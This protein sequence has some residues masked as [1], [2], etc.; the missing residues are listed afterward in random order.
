MFIVSFK[1][2]PKKVLIAGLALALAVSAGV[3]T[4]RYRGDKVVETSKAKTESVSEKS[5]VTAVK[6]KTEKK[7]KINTKKAAGKTNDQRMEFIKSFGWEVNPE[8]AEVME[9]IIPKEF[10]DVYKDYN[11]IQKMQGFDLSKYAGKRCKRYSYDIL[12]YPN[13]VENVRINL[14]IYKDKIVGG[15]VCTLNAGGF[16]H[17]FTH[18]NS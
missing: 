3:L 11:S 14:L 9:V 10:D 7:I 5:D 18:E 4:V 12:N 2:S 6:E 13:G 16:M 8:E 17:G 1:L 15:D